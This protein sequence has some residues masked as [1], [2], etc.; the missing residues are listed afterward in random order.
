MDFLETDAYCMLFL[1]QHMVLGGLPLL[2]ISIL[3]HDNAFSGNLGDFTT[4]DLLA[5]LYTSIFGS[6][7]SY[8]V[9]LYS[10]TKG[11]VFYFHLS[12]MT[13]SILHFA[14]FSI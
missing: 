3:N 6:A 2:V 11:I 14:N 5:L 13:F 10:A 12:V 8:G 9:Y 4:N 7:V 1:L